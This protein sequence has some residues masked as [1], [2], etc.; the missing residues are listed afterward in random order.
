M[1]ISQCSFNRIIVSLPTS[2][3]LL[4]LRFNFKYFFNLIT[5]AEVDQHF[6]H[7]SHT[8]ILFFRC[9]S[10]RLPW[11]LLASLHKHKLLTGGAVLHIRLVSDLCKYVSKPG[12]I[13]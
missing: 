11:F 9:T 6:N 13:L 10:R 1:A 3:K 8:N 4:L 2:H 5:V 12:A 7:V